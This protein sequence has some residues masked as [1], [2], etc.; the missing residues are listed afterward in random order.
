MVC[1]LG[2]LFGRCGVWRVVSLLTFLLVQVSSLLGQATIPPAL[3]PNGQAQ[4][5]NSGNTWSP[6]TSPANLAVGVGNN[7]SV[8]SFPNS[9]PSYP[10]NY[11]SSFG[12]TWNAT[13]PYSRPTPDQTA[14][15]VNSHPAL[16]SLDPVT[17]ANIVNGAYLPFLTS[18]AYLP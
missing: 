10:A 11:V 13:N 2:S 18:S 16:S 7:P 6:S 4:P 5:A 3:S 15:Y 9:V 12:N 17:K 8:S 1:P 14:T